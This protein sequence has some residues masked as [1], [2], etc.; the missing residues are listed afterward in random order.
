MLCSTMPT[1]EVSN[2]LRKALQSL[3]IFE[4]IKGLAALFGLLGLL[5]LLHHDLHRLAL[6]LIGHVGLSP[7]AHYPAA[8]IAAV[9]KVN[10][11]PIHTL[12]LLGGAYIALR[13]LEAWGLWHDLAW[14][15]WLGAIS[16][17][18][19]IPLE[20]QHFWAHRHWQGGLVLLFNIVLVIV[21]LIRLYQRRSAAHRALA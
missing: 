16:S 13:W 8:W 3:A 10:A 7:D 20:I 18:I 2:P 19:Y 14:G 9:D 12:V 11:T 5:S 15:E 1:T 4:A 17:G 21:L 6:E